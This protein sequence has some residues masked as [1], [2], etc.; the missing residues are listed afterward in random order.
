MQPLNASL[1]F[2]CFSTSLHFAQSVLRTFAQRGTF[3]L[4]NCLKTKTTTQLQAVDFLFVMNLRFNVAAFCCEQ[5][6][7]LLVHETKHTEERSGRRLSATDGYNIGDT[8]ISIR[9]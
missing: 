5:F 3:K 2:F 9:T 4:P 1:S 8:V 6:L 7:D